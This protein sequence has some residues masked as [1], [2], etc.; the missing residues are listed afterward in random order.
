VLKTYH[1][2]WLPV[3]TASQ[4][5]DAVNVA[6]EVASRL[7]ERKQIE[8]AI[9]AAIQQTEFPRSIHWQ[10]YGIAQG[11]AGL[12]IMCGYLN[13][14][15]PG[16]D[17]DVVGHS[18]L[19]TAVRDAEHHPYLPAGM[20]VGLAGLAFASWCLSQGGKRYRKLQAALEEPL[21]PQTV[22]L[23]NQL[24]EQK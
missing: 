5:A 23:A 12:A 15:F 7:R 14:C 20:C 2:L 24:A 13:T 10:D 4:A 11:Y 3:L 8:T 18:L 19:E 17:W 16:E 22:A 6:R 9:A 1:D 21:L